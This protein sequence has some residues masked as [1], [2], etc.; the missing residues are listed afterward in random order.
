DSVS[1]CSSVSDSVR[2]TTTTP[3]VAVIGNGANV[4]ICQDDSVILN[5]QPV[6]VGL[7]Y[8]W[9]GGASGVNDTNATVVVKSAGN[10]R[11]VVTD[12]RQCRDTSLVS[13][14]VVHSRP[15]AQVQPT[16]AVSVCQGD[17][18]DL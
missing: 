18:V 5:A 6:G 13:A 3:P 14:V 16:G 7:R 1:G 17:S 12:A 10:Y 9:I 15:T 2:L 11:V 4:S 8:R